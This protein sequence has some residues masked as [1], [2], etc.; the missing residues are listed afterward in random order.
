MKERWR[1]ESRPSPPP[2]GFGFGVHLIECVGL[3]LLLLLPPVR[4]TS[5][6]ATASAGN[7]AAKVAAKRVKPPGAS[8]VPAPNQYSL[9]ELEHGHEI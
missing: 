1:P 8:S 5:A 3:S 2:A 4:T 7:S 6:I 9:V